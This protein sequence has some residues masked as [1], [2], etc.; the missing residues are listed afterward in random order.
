MSKFSTEEKVRIVLDGRSK[1][2]I[3]GSNGNSAPGEIEQPPVV[4]KIEGGCPA[5]DTF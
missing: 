3:I 4:R 1:L 5:T 2:G